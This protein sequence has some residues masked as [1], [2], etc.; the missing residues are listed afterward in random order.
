[1]PETATLLPAIVMAIPP[2][3]VSGLNGYWLYGG[4]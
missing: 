4:F 1:M 2:V 3:L